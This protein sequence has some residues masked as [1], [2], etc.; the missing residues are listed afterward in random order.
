MQ[1][2]ND[3]MGSRGILHKNLV[4]APGQGIVEFRGE[5]ISPVLRVMSKEYEK[6]GKWSHSTW[7][8]EL[9]EGAT[10]LEW[11]Q[12]WGTGSWFKSQGLTGAVEELSAALPE[13]HG[14]NSAQVERAIR[15]IW[16]K[17]S[18][19]LAAEDAAF[20]SAG[21]QFGDLLEA[22]KEYASAL[23]EAQEVASAIEATEEAKRL[24]NQAA[25][26]K[27]AAA[28]AKGGKMSLADLKAMMAA[29]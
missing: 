11:H 18:S 17:T 10:I 15:S 7:T 1:K 9:R 20:T 26:L 25:K 5:S 3:R 14:L 16:P 13:G 19:A 12:D 2:I 22:Q 21:D 4:V 27:T 28:K 29:G 8:V 23:S 6:G 24:R